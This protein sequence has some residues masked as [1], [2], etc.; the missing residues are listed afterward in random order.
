MMRYSYLKNNLMANLKLNL[1]LL[2]NKNLLNLMKNLQ[3]E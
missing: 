2:I 1:Q 3:K